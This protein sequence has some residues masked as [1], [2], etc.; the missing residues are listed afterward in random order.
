[1]RTEA[2]P[3]LGLDSR[4]LHLK[5]YVLGLFNSSQYVHVIISQSLNLATIDPKHFTETTCTSLVPFVDRTERAL[6]EFG[7]N[8]EHMGDK[9]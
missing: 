5:P 4:A 6:A 3:P 9:L 2:F 1:M 7:L 8:V